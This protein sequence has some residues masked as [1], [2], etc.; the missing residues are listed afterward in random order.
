[1][2]RQRKYGFA[3]VAGAALIFLVSAR[4]RRKTRASGLLPIP[5]RSAMGVRLTE[6][7]H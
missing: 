1:M 3:A 5:R 4:S 7:R 2:R 6:R